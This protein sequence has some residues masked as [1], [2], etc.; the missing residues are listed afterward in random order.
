MPKKKLTENFIKN[1]APPAK[2]VEYYDTLVQGLIL[3]H[4]KAGTK[5]FCY[6]YYDEQRHQRQTIGK[7]PAYSLA[8]ARHK[9]HT[10]KNPELYKEQENS[11]SIYTFKK[12]AELFKQHHLPALRMSTRNEYTRII[13]RELLPALAE[14]E[15]SSISVDHIEKLLD[16]K[17]NREAAPT[18]ANRMRAVLSSIF[19][20]GIDQRI[21]AL[22]PV[23]STDMYEARNRQS[24]R[25]YNELEIRELWRCFGKQTQPMGEL[26]KILLVQGQQKNETLQMRWQ[27][28][29]ND[30]WTIPAEM[31][32]SGD[33]NKVPLG[34]ISQQVIQSL[35]PYSG[36][37]QYVFLSPRK[38]NAPLTTTKNAAQRIRK[39]SSV[40]D[41]KVRYLRQTVCVY[42]AKLGVERE[43][44]LKLFN[45]KEGK[46]SLSSLYDKQS[47]DESKKKA[48]SRWENC[49][50]DILGGG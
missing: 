38:Q 31:S 49:L 12:V 32:R 39:V 14:F 33:P 35:K 13:D 18:M 15:I 6:R 20:F 11:D 41:F 10:Y 50:L 1:L 47:H 3:R 27:D 37:S 46:S 17:A 8:E 40:K 30:I 16:H 2:Q 36:N 5:S 19:S 29:E 4:T 43:V 28:I 42:M 23:H 7:Y 24:K 25:H 21:T 45:Y 48:I 34:N 44:L 22:N 9:V 26:L